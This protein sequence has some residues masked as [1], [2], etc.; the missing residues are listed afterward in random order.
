MKIIFLVLIISLFYGFA[1][2]D[3]LSIPFS[4]YPKAIQTKFLENNL[5]LDLDGNDR[6]KE[7]WGYLKNEGAK[8]IIY[9]YRSVTK[10]EL[11]IV[12]RIAREIE[13][14]QNNGK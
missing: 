2:S 1:K 5:K 7:T 10:E 14:E 12:L 8:Y 3:E 4:C 11:S 9:T 6:T 13:Y